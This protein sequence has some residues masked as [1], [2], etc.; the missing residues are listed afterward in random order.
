MKVKVYDV[1]DNLVKT[2]NCCPIPETIDL[3]GKQY[4]RIRLGRFGRNY[5]FK[6]DPQSKTVVKINGTLN[7]PHTN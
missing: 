3:M 6:E 1:S 5:I 2:V 7:R 4:K